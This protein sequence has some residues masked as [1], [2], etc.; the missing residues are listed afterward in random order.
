MGEKAKDLGG[1]RKEWIRL[2]NLSIKEKYFDHG[3]RQY[4]ADDYC[5]M[6]IALLQ[7]GQLPTFFMFLAA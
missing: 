7:N 1:P 4:L 3:L 2:L 5:Y 6:G